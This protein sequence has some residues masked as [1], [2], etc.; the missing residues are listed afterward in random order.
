MD[1]HGPMEISDERLVGQLAILPEN[2]QVLIQSFGGL[3]KFL[4]S[5]TAFVKHE[6][7]IC[8][9]EYAAVVAASMDS[10]N[11]GDVP[12]PS[13]NS[14]SLNQH[15]IVKGTQELGVYELKQKGYSKINKDPL[16]GGGKSSSV[17][18]GV[19]HGRSLYASNNYNMGGVGV[20]KNS[21]MSHPTSRQGY[22]TPAPPPG[23]NSPL[24]KSPYSNKSMH[25]HSNNSNCSNSSHLLEGAGRKTSNNAKH[26]NSKESLSGI[27]ST[28][29]PID[30][31]LAFSNAKKLMG[32][33]SS[34]STE[35]SQ[36]GPNG[37]DDE[38]IGNLFDYNAFGTGSSSN[39][40]SPPSSEGFF[41][42]AYPQESIDSANLS[43]I[44]APPMD[45]TVTSKP[46][47]KF[48]SS[49]FESAIAASNAMD[50]TEDMKPL[51]SGVNMKVATTSGYNK[52]TSTVSSGVNI[53]YG[54]GRHHMEPVYLPPPPPIVPQPLV[55]DKKDAC[56]ETDIVYVYLENYKEK[57]EDG[58]K[59]QSEVVKRLQESEDRRVQMSKTHAVE[60]D[61]AVR[62]ATENAKLVMCTLCVVSW[63]VLW[64]N[65]VITGWTM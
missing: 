21:A 35:H 34:T 6:G 59:S 51:P 47:K 55:V 22:H 58:V 16:L 20:K 29:D 8:L 50:Y 15:D 41:P 30:N 46:P 3:E 33:T 13:L 27:N 49:K 48:S 5:S 53:S 62:R 44:T 39:H 4:L 24:G 2:S 43:D 60:M 57:Y 23:L 42:N 11:T 18:N 38:L 26:H 17:I 63:W 9:A 56:V 40:L 36:E 10:S 64:L 12:K 61:L 45:T 28:L 52:N 19:A 7:L 32:L 31:T 54:N 65:Y 25:M 37:E 14:D 1:K